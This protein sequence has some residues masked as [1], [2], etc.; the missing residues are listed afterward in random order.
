MGINTWAEGDRPREKLLN[1]G[2]SY[3]S[4]AELVAILLGSGSSKLSALDL[5]KGIMARFDNN[6]HELQKSDHN[7]LIAFNGVGPA[8]A[9]MIRAALEIGR[10]L[11]QSKAKH[12]AP[13]KCSAD[14]YAIL[15]PILAHKAHEE[16][17][18]LFLNN[19][20]CLI[21]PLLL[22]KGGLT[23]TVV[24]KREVFRWALDLKSTNLILA[25]NHPSGSLEASLADKQ[26]TNSLVEAGKVMDI[27]IL[28]HL[29]V[30]ENGFLS[31]SDEAL[32]P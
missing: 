27:T 30:S 21:Q 26:L 19:R 24:D 8:K 29:I 25:H 4:D 23:G 9:V 18:V 13:I 2:A 31:F 12:K 10:R 15:E 22:S 32:I 7:Q 3:L 20:N 28:D 6:L 5:A 1:Q 11:K 14:A 17:W 16:F